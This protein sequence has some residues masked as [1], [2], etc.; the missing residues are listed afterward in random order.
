MA[1]GLGQGE[2]GW[3]KSGRVR[4]GQVRGLWAVGCG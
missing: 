1:A 2:K 3:F 4:P